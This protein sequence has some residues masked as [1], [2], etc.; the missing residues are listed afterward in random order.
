VRVRPVCLALF[1]DGALALGPLRG[2]RR[3][4]DR[5][6]VCVRVGPPLFLGAGNLGELILAQRGGEIAALRRGVV[7]S[8]T[9][10]APGRL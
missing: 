7:N 10:A 4:M 8:L 1:L 3:G 9:A 2:N 5:E 6:S